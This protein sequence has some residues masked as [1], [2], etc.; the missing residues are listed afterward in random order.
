LLA[1]QP[2]HF[3]M[4]GAVGTIQWRERSWRCR[5]VV[6]DGDCEEPLLFGGRDRSALAEHL[7]TDTAVVAS[8]KH[9]AMMDDH[10]IRAKV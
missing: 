8:D 4:T 9:D 1:D 7:H 2:L 6:R 10:R 5:A 3:D